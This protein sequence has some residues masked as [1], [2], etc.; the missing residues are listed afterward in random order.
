MLSNYL[1]IDYHTIPDGIR[2]YT[3]LDSIHIYIYMDLR[4]LLGKA[5]VNN[6]NDDDGTQFACDGHGS[7][8]WW[9]VVGSFS[10]GGRDA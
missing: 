1:H 10:T 6:H 4:D 9:V 7:I 5:E 3:N 2:T 8:G